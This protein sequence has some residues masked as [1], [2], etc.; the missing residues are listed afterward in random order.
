[1]LELRQQHSFYGIILYVAATVFVIY[2]SNGIPAPDTWNSLF[3]IT[4]L[5]VCVNA[6]AKS[7]LQES[8]GRMLYFY[9]IAGPVTFILSRLI[10]NGILMVLMS[11]ITLVLFLLFLENPLYS[12]LQFILV[13]FAGGLSLSFVFTFLAAIAAKAKQSAALMAVM[14]FPLIIPQLILLLKISNAAF[15]RVQEGYWFMIAVV[16]ALSAMVVVLSVILFPF[17]WKD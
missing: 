12:I 14:G 17:L 5:F 3:W 9:S 16:F 2:L 13:A 15:A 1:M 4:Q 8:P 6:V 10:Y 11:A 7:F